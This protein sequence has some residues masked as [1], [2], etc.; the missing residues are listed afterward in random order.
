MTAAWATRCTSARTED[1]I[2]FGDQLRRLDESR[3]GYRL[4]KKLTREQGRLAPALDELCP[5]WRERETFAC[6]LPRCSTR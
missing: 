4:E 3:T 5:D 1:D 6:G 2:I